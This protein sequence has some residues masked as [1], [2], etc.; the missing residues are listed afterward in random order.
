MLLNNVGRLP[1]VDRGDP[2][3]MV[4]YLNRAS[5]MA[6][7][8]Q[9]LHEELVREPGWLEGLVRDGNS[10]LTAEPQTLTGRV[11]SIERDRLQIDV[12]GSVREFLLRAPASGISPGDPVRIGF[13]E[14]EGHSVADHVEELLSRQ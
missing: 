10:S 6:C 2:Q 8:G 14:S 5:V 12:G 4:G 7:W 3:K 11:V 1:V 13:R 9:H